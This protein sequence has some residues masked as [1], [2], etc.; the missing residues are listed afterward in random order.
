MRA[1]SMPLLPFLLLAACTEYGLGKQG[2]DPAAAVP[3]I[4]V[5]PQSI[6]EIVCTAPYESSVLVTNEGDGPLTV[7]LVST[8]GDWTATAD[9]PVTLL[10]GEGIPV[11]LSGSGPG[12]L[13][14]SS[15]DPDEAE[16]AVPLDVAVNLPPTATVD[17]PT[18]GTILAE[19]AAD[20]TLAGTVYDPDGDTLD[21]T[22][23]V[24]GA[25]LT[26][27]SAVSGPVSALWL[28][29][30]AGDHTIGITASDACGSGAA[31]VAVCQ[32]ETITYE[33]LGISTWHYEGAA[34]WD[35]VAGNLVLTDA[36]QDQVGSAFDTTATVSGGSVDIDFDFYIGDGSGADGISL[37][38]LDSGRMTS[39]LGGTGCGIGYGG[40][41]DCTPGP[42]LP[43]WSIEVDTYY[44]GGYDPT[45]EDH[46]AFT[47]D[48]DVD[49]PAVWAALPEMEDTGWH[50]MQVSVTDPHVT[51]VIDGITYIDQ[52]L[53]GYFGFPAYVGFTAG[54][55]GE[56]NRH[57]IQALTVT[58]RACD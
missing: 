52:D 41:A 12:T 58:D 7:S 5:D 33:N 23:L 8:T 38:A 21:V 29:P 26:S 18:D 25:P 22:W 20:Q 54:T 6:S 3:D 39:F 28:A 4:A 15:D 44:N 36:I 32:D 45:P 51:V 49:G 14:L 24:D 31:D 42:A 10:T 13:T 2:K 47:F 30:A 34:Y 17:S 57:L 43:G 55:G 46:I 9:L 37:T 40:S 50:T 56:T 53:S 27:G 48:G 35:T 19:P 1:L 11:A 16:L